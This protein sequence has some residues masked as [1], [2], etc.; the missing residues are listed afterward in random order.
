MGK[1]KQKRLGELFLKTK[2][3]RGHIISEVVNV[4]PVGEP[5]HGPQEAEAGPSMSK[6][7]TETSAAT[8]S[9]SDHSIANIRYL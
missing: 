6:Q 3:N 5:P 9:S 7:T 2:K 4:S 8:G 1:R